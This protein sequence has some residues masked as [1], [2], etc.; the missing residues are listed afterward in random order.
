LLRTTMSLLFSVDPDEVSLLGSF[1]LGYSEQGFE[2]YV[3]PT[4]TESHLVDGGVPELALR[5]G[6]RLGPALHLSSPVRSIKQSNAGVEVFSDRLTIEARRVIVATR[7][8]WP[9]GLNTIRRFRNPVRS[10]FVV[11]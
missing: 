3:D 9:V 10:W 2:Y 5:L 1:V 8:S 4:I 11:W 6:A 7:P